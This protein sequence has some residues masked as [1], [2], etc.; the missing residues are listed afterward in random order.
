MFFASG[1]NVWRRRLGVA[2]LGGKM[3]D[4]NDHDMPEVGKYNGGQKLLFW[5]FAL[6]L[7][8]LLVTGR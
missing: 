4:G 7:L 2:G 6:C 8:V 5:L 3:V 1:A